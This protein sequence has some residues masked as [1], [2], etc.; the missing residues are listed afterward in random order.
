MSERILLSIVEAAS[1]FT[2]PVM[3][4][5]ILLYAHARGVKVY[6]VFVAGAARGIQT[7]LHI[8]PYLIA[9]WVALGLL[10]ASGVL[11]LAFALCEPV[12]RLLGVP[13]Q[14]LP[15]MIIRPLSG[16]GALGADERACPYLRPRFRCGLPG[17]LDQGSTETTFYVITVY[18]G[19]VGVKKPRHGLA[20]ALV[21]DLTGF[22]AAV[23]AWRILYRT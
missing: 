2:I 19:A 12:L 23:I 5:V 3:L 18:L 13:V 4:M 14:I 17:L 15:L 6:E 1:Q 20:A 9:M 7:T 8:L 16:S 11:D 10:R 22:I 21:G